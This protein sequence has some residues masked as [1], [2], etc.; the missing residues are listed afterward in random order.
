MNL[1]ANRHAQVCFESRH[2][3]VCEVMRERQ[4]I[5]NECKKLKDERDK[6]RK[7]IRDHIDESL[8]RKE[9]QRKA[10]PV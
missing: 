2:C 9:K 1:C 4:L 10:L 6:A 8:T 3:P 7:A 5:E